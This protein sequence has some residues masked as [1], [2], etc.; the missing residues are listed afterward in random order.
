MKADDFF[1]GPV[2]VDGVPC[3]Q[4]HRR[5]HTG[6]LASCSSTGINPVG[7]AGDTSPNI[8][9]GDVNGNIPPNIIIDNFIRKIIAAQLIQR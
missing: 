1:V 5:K 6:T 7:D 2:Q 4:R 9:V 8:L 3:N